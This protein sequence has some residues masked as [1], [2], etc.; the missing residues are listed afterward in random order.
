MAYDPN[1][2]KPMF[3][4]L[5]YCLRCGMPSTERDA[6]FDELGICQTC[7]SLEQKMYMD[8]TEREN[9]LR[10]LFDKYRGKYEYDCIVPISGGKDSAFQLHLIVN[11]FK[12]KTLGVTF[13]HNWFSETG[14]KNL[15]WCLETFNVDHIMFTPS[16]SLV[17]RCARRSLEM[18][19]D[20]CW[21][22]H[23]GV[24]AFPWQTAV[25]YKIPLLI[26]GES[27]AETSPSATY[28]DQIP[29]D[30]DYFF[31]QSAGFRANEFATDYLSER[32]LA[33][34]KTPSHK[35]IEELGVIGIHLGN[36]IFW[37][38]ERQMEILRDRYGWREDRV[39]GTYKC[40]KSVECRMPGMHDFTKFL[41][42]GY[43]RTTDHVAQD[44]RAGL[45]TASEG[46]R[47][48]R[49]F[50]PRTPEM[51]KEY[52]A[53]SDYSEEEFYAIMDRHREKAGALTAEE[54][55]AALDDFQRNYGDR[56]QERPDERA[57]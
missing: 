40:Y 23:A 4:S 14:M 17:N 53:I 28:E 1:P 18:I 5:H 48:I 44:R 45:M 52:L 46:N 29:M 21:H 33:P 6:S 19:G 8:W 51:L 16:R 15:R 3:T 9:A 38:A 35:E 30:V 42:R 12:L 10:A 11:V 47:L 34:F 26:Y 22:C 56:T 54:I 2:D 25:R 49:E 32:D 55:R 37:D 36:Y 13:S 43:G 39:E 7:T 24:G 31:D 50:D 41:K 57:E 27:A 20:T